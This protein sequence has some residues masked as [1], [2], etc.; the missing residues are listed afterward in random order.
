VAVA[1]IITMFPTLLGFDV[2]DAPS[3]L[4]TLLDHQHVMA[5][6]GA[7]RHEAGTL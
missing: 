3:E 4:Q 2:G 1:L 7:H 6:F 5:N